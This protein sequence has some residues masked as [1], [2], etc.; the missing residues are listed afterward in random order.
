MIPELEHVN[1]SDILLQK[2]P[3]R[4]VDSLSAMTSTMTQARFRVKP[5]S[6]FLDGDRLDPSALLEVMAQT[7][8]ARQGYV[9][10]YLLHK[11]VE[12]GY[13]GAVRDFVVSGDARVGDVLNTTIEIHERFADL[14]VVSA[15]T[16]VNSREIAR[17]TLRLSRGHNDLFAGKSKSTS[18]IWQ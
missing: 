1:V 11:P 2:E 6:P 14:L 3:V 16:M 5:D 13:I 15:V 4:M 7:C 17:C 12:V 18:Q 8:A 9:N 10:K